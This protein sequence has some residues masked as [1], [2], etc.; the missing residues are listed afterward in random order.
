LRR[1]AGVGPHR[2][3]LVFLL[4][5]LSFTFTMATPDG[6]W[7]RL[8]TAGIQSGAL[9]T[10][11]ASSAGSAKFLRL[12][13]AVVV[14]NLAVAALALFG[15]GRVAAA[16]GL[17]SAGLLVAVVVAIV[18]GFGRTPVVSVQSLMGGLSIYLLIGMFFAAVYGS[19]ARLS[20]AAFFS[21]EGRSTASDYLYFSF[22]TLATVGYGDLV[23]ITRIGRTLAAVE[24]LTGQ[25][26][27][28]TVIALLVANLG[29]A[30]TPGAPG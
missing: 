19:V 8:V 10:A 16:S 30:R 15:G 23:P 25:L 6:A 2:Y 11:L 5:A 7:S 27:P 17:V 13:L 20:G 22:I 12:G 1:P 9:L 28:V 21:G 4:L 26:Y 29:R 18:R 3:G 24:G 14:L